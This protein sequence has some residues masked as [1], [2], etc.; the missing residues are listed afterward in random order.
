MAVV[1]TLVTVV[2]VLAVVAYGADYND[3]YYKF[4]LGLEG[5][6]SYTAD[7]RLK[8]LKN[9]PVFFY[10]D[11]SSLPDAMQYVLVSVF[12]SEAPNTSG[13]EN[14]TSQADLYKKGEN[15]PYV[16][17]MVSKTIKYNIYNTFNL[18]PPHN[19]VYLGGMADH[20]EPSLY[21]VSGKWSPDDTMQPQYVDATY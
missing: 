7:V 12:A 2:A 10:A 17:C 20:Y 14:V 11:E 5:Q 8:W 13:R 18:D 15:V 19:Y 1:L 4:V 6:Y 9:S 21:T 16:Y 3:T